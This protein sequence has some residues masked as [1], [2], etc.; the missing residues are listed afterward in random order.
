MSTIGGPGGIGGPKGPGGPE[1]PDGPDDLDAA[2][3]AP[4]A[5]A[6]HSA[7]ALDPATA[8]SHV[9]DLDALA[10]EVSA[11]RLTPHEAIERLIDATAGPD[12][13]ATERAELR[14]ML[15]DLVANDPHLA[16]LAGRI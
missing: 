12:L 10:A 5:P 8:A 9:G 3:S 7:H 6:A 13:G 11:G 1:G 16:A 14:E 4:A 2:P 15:T